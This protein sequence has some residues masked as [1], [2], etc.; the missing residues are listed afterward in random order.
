MVE[1]SGQQ[2]LTFAG[3]ADDSADAG[4]AGQDWDVEFRCPETGKLF[5]DRVVLSTRPGARVL[6]VRSEP[7]GSAARPDWRE[8]EVGEWI[9]S[10]AG[11][12]RDFC[13]TM[14]GAGTAAL[15]LYFAV[16]KLLGLESAHGGWRA[17]TLGPPVLFLAATVVF[18]VALRP[19][20]RPIDVA[21]VEAVR[22]HRLRTM[23]RA[24]T[25]GL[26]LFGMAMA[27]SLVLFLV[28]LWR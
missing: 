7:A 3:P 22:E 13:R 9:K 18:V 12:G 11:T 2:V 4:P 23:N 6:S 5:T 17:A 8:A 21:T 16:L 15:P 14:I 20:L 19:A 28:L 24:I 25:G 26:V 10:S 1:M 27:H